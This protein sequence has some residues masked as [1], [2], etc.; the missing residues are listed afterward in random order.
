MSIR[1]VR[2]TRVIVVGMAGM[3]ITT[4]S[5]A[6]VTA[7][8]DGGGPNG[9]IA[10]SNLIDFSTHGDSMGLMAGSFSSDSFNRGRS[11]ENL[12]NNTEVEFNDPAKTATWTFGNLPE[13]STWDIFS[14]LI[15]DG[16]TQGSDLYNEANS[17]GR[18]PGTGTIEIN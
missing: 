6:V 4:T 7:V 2:R 15:F 13:G 1:K 18:T 3:A 12:W 9:N 8:M 10:H 5:L 16:L 14:T 17:G 11:V